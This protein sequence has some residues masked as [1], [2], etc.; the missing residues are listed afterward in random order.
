ML[1]HERV[2]AKIIEKYIGEHLSVSEIYCYCYLKSYVPV[3]NK[4]V[5]FVNNYYSLSCPKNISD[6]RSLIF[7]TVVMSVI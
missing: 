7:V 4:V 6:N 1:W 3:N 2:T 5:A